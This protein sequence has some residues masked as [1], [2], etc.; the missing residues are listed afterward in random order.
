MVV[1]ADIRA[2]AARIAVPGGAV[3]T[4][5]LPFQ[6]TLAPPNVECHV[7]CEHL[8]RTGSFKFRG[9][10]SAV[11]ALSAADAKRGFVAHSSGNHGAAV[12]AA[13]SARGVP[14]TIV[15]P[16]T[17]PAAKLENI[18]RYGANLVLCEP[19][20]SARTETSKR[21]AERTGGTLVHPYNDPEVICGQG[22]IALELLEQVPGLDAILVPVSGG[23]M[24]GGIATAA[25]TLDPGVRVFACEPH[26]K[27][28]QQALAAGVRVV[29]PDTVELPLDTICDAIRSRALGPR[30]WELAQAHVDPTVLT[31]ND[32]DV[33]AALH[34]TMSELKQC[35]EPAG[36]VAL[37]AFLSPAFAAVCEEAARTERPIRK[38]GLIACGGN[39]D[40]KQV[41]REVEAHI[42]RTS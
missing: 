31:V 29:E 13:A 20:Q 28:L 10:L 16:N 17:T 14:A 40:L 9:A 23:G 34:I 6:H 37:A 35:V 26:G 21:E 5:V 38:V 22:T 11:F 1:L 25:R 41:L 19:T 15:V 33:R 7:K 30:P 42:D 18:K 27:K 36:A 8:Q 12:A 39:A 3:R 24:I 32:D 2:A 4:A